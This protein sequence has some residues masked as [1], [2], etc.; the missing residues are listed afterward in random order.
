MGQV[1]EIF[2]ID[3]QEISR[4]LNDNTEIEKYINTLELRC[5]RPNIHQTVMFYIDKQWRMCFDLLTDYLLHKYLHFKD[6]FVFE[7]TT[8]I[9][10][11]ETVNDLNKI[12]NALNLDV[13]LGSSNY[14]KSIQEWLNEGIDEIINAFQIASK[15]NQG[16][17]ISIG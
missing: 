4:L 8:K 6:V 16:L 17:I 1:C 9:I 7:S 3:S 11:K 5:N 10:S 14:K 12:F 13:L 15:E 2:R